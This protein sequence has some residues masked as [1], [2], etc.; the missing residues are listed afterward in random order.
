MGQRMSC[1]APLLSAI[2]W[3]LLGCDSCLTFAS[4]DVV[5]IFFMK[6]GLRFAFKAL[7][8]SKIM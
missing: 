1:I 6:L 2:T 8:K 5:W 4:N 7:S 3:G